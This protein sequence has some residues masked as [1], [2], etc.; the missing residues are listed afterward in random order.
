L[1]EL[2][3]DLE[4]DLDACAKLELKVAKLLLD[5]LGH[6]GKVEAVVGALEVVSTTLET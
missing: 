3:A 6:V 4:L 2:D 5:V 1:A